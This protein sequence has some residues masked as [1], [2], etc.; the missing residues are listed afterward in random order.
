MGKIVDIEKARD[1]YSI[2]IAKMAAK[3]LYGSPDDFIDRL[4]RNDATFKK[5]VVDIAQ[6]ITRYEQWLIDNKL[7]KGGVHG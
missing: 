7:L 1:E 3:T 4:S 6:E 5:L 2:R